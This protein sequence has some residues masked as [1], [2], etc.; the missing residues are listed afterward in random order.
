VSIRSRVLDCR[1]Q[2]AH[3]IQCHQ[4]RPPKYQ[5][6]ETPIEGKS[7][8]C[9]LNQTPGEKWRC[10]G[11]STDTQRAAERGGESVECRLSKPTWFHQAR[12]NETS[13]E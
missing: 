2:L 4:L 11:R 3:K 5:K 6:N 10:E 7:N 9:A 1:R 8:T 13:S 12:F